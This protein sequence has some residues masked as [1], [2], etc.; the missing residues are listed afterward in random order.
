M[1]PNRKFQN[2]FAN[3]HERAA[4]RVSRHMSDKTLCRTWLD[5]SCAH[6][7][8]I[9]EQTNFKVTHSVCYD[10]TML[11]LIQIQETVY[12]PAYLFDWIYKGHT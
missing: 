6:P 3:D 2:V 5:I 8:F 9:H 12:W 10:K 4:E 11:R 7:A 1:W